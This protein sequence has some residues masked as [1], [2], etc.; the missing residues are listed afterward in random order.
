MKYYRNKP[1]GIWILAVLIILSLIYYYTSPVLVW[2][3]DPSDYVLV[4]FT[5][6]FTV[7]AWIS[8]ILDII[9]VYAV[10]V[11]FSKA[12]NWAR[13]YTM[14]VLAIPAVFSV[15]FIFIK[16]VWPYERY[17]WIVLYVIV[18]S[19][20]MMSEVKEYFGVKKWFF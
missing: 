15:Y 3:M 13:L 14:I 19:Y 1:L 20:L 5:G 9:L 2:G 11:G 16:G 17:A 4:N 7:V 8:V 12:K 6:W 18:V 10:T